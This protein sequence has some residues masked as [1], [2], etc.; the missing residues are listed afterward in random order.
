[1]YY[2]LKLDLNRALVFQNDCQNLISA[3]NFSHFS[4][5][6]NVEIQKN[7]PLYF[8]ALMILKLP[9]PLGSHES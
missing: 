8:S 9:L 4:Y 3:L 2:F 5:L 7:Q 1:M 6:I